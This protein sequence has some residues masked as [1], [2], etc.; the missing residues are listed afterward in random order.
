MCG[1]EAVWS[2]KPCLK[3]L[4]AWLLLLTLPAVAQV[5]FTYTTNN[6][7][8]TLTH[9]TGS[10]GAVTIP[11]AI[12]G[13]PVTGIGYEAF[14]GSGL[15]SVTIPGS[16]TSIGDSAFENCYDLSSVAIP[17]SVTSIGNE[18]FNECT[19]LNGV[20]IGNGVTNIGVEAFDYCT[21]LHRVMLGN[22]VTSIGASAFENCYSLTSVTFQGNPPGADSSVFSS[23]NTGG[24]NATVYYLPGATNWGPLFAG[25]P[26]MLWNA[27]VQTSG[28]G[29]GVRTNRFGLTITGASNL[30]IVVEGCTNLANPVWSPVG[31]NT[32]A[33]G[34]SYFSDPR[35][36]NSP[37]R[38][39][40][41]RPP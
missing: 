37:R 28:G 18:A 7:A 30:V 17:D 8:I 5:Q 14:L 33:A 26:A 31:T 20:T 40:R 41:L 27:Q 36:T 6:G 19:S 23:D 10:G 21:G 32:L 13:L 1:G 29:F 22:N 3:R 16:V 35:W 38:F 11:S 4:L 2:M 25:L 24:S 12:N 9:Y 15:T 34:V 39:Y